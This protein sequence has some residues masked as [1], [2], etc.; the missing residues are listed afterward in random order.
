MEGMP[1]FLSFNYKAN[2]LNVEVNNLKELMDVAQCDTLA[3]PLNCNAQAI[4]S[5]CF[6]FLCVDLNGLNTMRV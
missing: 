4:E 5:K 3:V 1:G 6:P 2:T